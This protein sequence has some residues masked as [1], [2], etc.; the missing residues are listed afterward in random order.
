MTKDPKKERK[1]TKALLRPTEAELEAL[2]EQVH[3]LER[4]ADAA[5][6]KGDGITKRNVIQAA[7]RDP[8]NL[9]NSVFAQSALSPVSTPAPTIGAP[10]LVAAPALAAPTAAPT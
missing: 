5:E 2:R 7:P 9:P 1:K 8:V 10:T 6:K 3:K 4:S